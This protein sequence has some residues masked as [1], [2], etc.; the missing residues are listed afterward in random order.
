[1]KQNTKEMNV[2][3]REY[4]QKVNGMV[5]LVKLYITEELIVKEMV[6][7]KENK[8]SKP[9]VVSINLFDCLKIQ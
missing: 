4:Y 5:R 8:N 2:K 3:K 7:I 6:N 1:M 9:K